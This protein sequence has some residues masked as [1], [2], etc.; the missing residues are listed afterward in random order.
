MNCPIC[1]D[2]TQK[3]VSHECGVGKMNMCHLCST[4]TP[5]QHYYLLL[6]RIDNTR[7]TLEALL[8]DA[9]AIG[10]AET[11]WFCEKSIAQNLKQRNELNP[12]KGVA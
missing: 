1:G 7:E 5:R 3:L 6:A 8:K 12:P 4:K 2:E 10:D 11:I 9:R